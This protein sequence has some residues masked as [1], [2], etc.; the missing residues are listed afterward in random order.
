M[1]D[2]TNASMAGSDGQRSDTTVD[3]SKLTPNRES[4]A[5]AGEVGFTYHSNYGAVVSLSVDRVKHGLEQASIKLTGNANLGLEIAKKLPKVVGITEG[6]RRAMSKAG[7]SLPTGSEIR[8]LE[9]NSKGDVVIVVG[10]ALKDADA[11]TVSELNCGGVAL[12]DSLGTMVTDV[13]NVGYA[14]AL[15]ALKTTYDTVRGNL[16]GP[17]IWSLF[18][19]VVQPQADDEEREWLVVGHGMIFT[20][21][22]ASVRAA[23]VSEMLAMIGSQYRIHPIPW[24][25]MVD[26]P[27]FDDHEYTLSTFADDADKKYRTALELAIS[28]GKPDLELAGKVLKLATESLDEH[29]LVYQVYNRMAEDAAKKMEELGL[30]AQKS[31]GI[32]LARMRG[33]TG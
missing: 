26:D 17:K 23:V 16:V 8:N 20:K 4:A 3:V 10:Q 33:V 1:S 29:R 12:V 19:D 28:T 5:L 13:Y 22:K 7:G 25:P 15:N 14:P 27:H 21:G 6:I 31:L 32:R 2:I 11:Q 18:G 24:R 9:A 30:L